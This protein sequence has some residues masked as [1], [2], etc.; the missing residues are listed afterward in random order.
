[1]PVG[2][3]HWTMAGSSPRY[4]QRPRIRRHS[5][6]CH[7]CLWLSEVSFESWPMIEEALLTGLTHNSNW[8]W[9]E[10][11]GLHDFRGHLAHS[12]RWDDEYSFDNKRVAVIGCGSSAIQIV[13]QIQ[14]SKCSCI[15][16]VIQPIY[17]LSNSCQAPHVL[18][19][20]GNM[21]CTRVCTTART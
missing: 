6:R 4:S 18:Q 9:P 1:M 7:K 13:P 2:R 3:L 19:S 11:P 17:L 14:P 8:K 15:S 16:Q 12:A 5:G 20:F 10:I 21:D